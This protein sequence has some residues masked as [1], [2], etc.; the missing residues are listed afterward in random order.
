MVEHNIRDPRTCSSKQQSFPW[1]L[2]RLRCRD[3][4]H[5][6]TIRK[7]DKT[8]GSGWQ[9]SWPIVLKEK[10]S[11]GCEKSELESTPT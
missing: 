8:S 1:N 3:T 7:A 11:G 6:E 2:L 4:H 9:K 10:P 5:N